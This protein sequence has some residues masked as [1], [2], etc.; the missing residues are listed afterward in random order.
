MKKTGRKCCIALI[1]CILTAVFV[2]AMPAKAGNVWEFCVPSGS[3]AKEIQRYLDMNAG[4]SLDQLILHFP[5]GEYK[6]DRALFIYPKTTI[7]ADEKAHF[8]K[9]KIYGALLEGKLTNDQGGYGSCYDITIEGGIWDSEPVMVNGTGTETFRFIHARDITLKNAVICNVPTGSHLVVFAGCENVMVDGC[10]F[11]GYGKDN[12]SAKIA[13]EAIQLDVAHDAVIVPTFQNVKWDDLPCR[14]VTIQNCDF[15]DF[16]RAFGSHTAVKGI[17]HDNVLLENNTIRNMSETA[18]K[19]FCYT[20][21]TVRKNTIENCVE[22]I[23]VYTE[24]TDMKEEEYLV[25]IQEMDVVIPDTHNVLIEKNTIKNVK[26]K[27]QTW[28]DGIRVIG[29]DTFP[30]RGVSIRNNIIDTA[31]RYGIFI[32]E[33]PKTEIT[34]NSIKATSKDGILVS[35]YST[36]A[37]V[38][39]NTITDSGKSGIAIYTGSHRTVVTG[40]EISN[41]EEA[42]IYLFDTVK[43]CVIGDKDAGNIIR[44]TGISGIHITGDCKNNSIRNNSISKADQCGI[45]VYQSTG[46]KLVSNRIT[47]VGGDGISVNTKSTGNLLEKNAISAVGKNGIWVSGSTGCTLKSNS[48]TDYGSA[49]EKFYGIGIYQ[50][51]GTSKKKVSVYGNKISGSDAKA[52]E[53]KVI[54]NNGINVSTS[55]YVSLSKN[56]VKNADGT[57]IYVYQSKNCLADS[58]T[59]TSPARQ[60]IYFTTGCDKAYIK[61][62]TV[63]GSADTAI[64]IYQAPGSTITANKV[65]VTQEIVGIRISSSDNVKA[66]KNTVAGAADKRSV[67]FT[68]SNNG[69]ESGNIIK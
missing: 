51:G 57:G 2:Q 58:N 53:K 50:S 32:T 18:I 29:G 59:V 68:G 27:Q 56:S 3:S 67:W 17:Y 36:D 1:L 5:E 46:N 24:M 49:G 30:I 6:L 40:N 12:S 31:S 44:E 45:W 33:A 37:K 63:K 54:I 65:S 4:G 62:N 39:D 28:G 21:T 60:G 26:T 35:I 23:L 10:T 64:M 8:I 41:A 20:N 11:Y 47:D 38:Q 42:G 55:N 43:D 7:L 66:T 25:P 34:G 16:S 22:G 69:T 52:S 61:A 13:K 9:T 15:H 48:I 19:L 14:N